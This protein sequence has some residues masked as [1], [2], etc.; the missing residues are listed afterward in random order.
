MNARRVRRAVATSA[1]RSQRNSQRNAKRALRLNDRRITGKCRHTIAVGYN[2]GVFPL[3][4]GNDGFNNPGRLAI[5]SGNSDI[6]RCVDSDTRGS[7]S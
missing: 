4:L 5:Y 7:F 6:M 1:L 3:F 2:I